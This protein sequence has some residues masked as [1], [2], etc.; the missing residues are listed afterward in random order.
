[1]ANILTTD[2]VAPRQRVAYWQEMVSRTFVQAHCDS[3]AGESFRGRISTAAFDQTEI[4]RIDAGPQRIQRRAVDIARACK[5]RFYL[6][7]HAAG[8]ARYREGHA[9]NVLGPGDMILLDNCEPYS[10]EY[11]EPVTSI[12]LH[13]PHEILRDR[14]RL[15]ERALGRRL[16][17][18]RG[19][20]RIAGEFLQSCIAQA[21]SLSPAQRAATAGVALDLFSSVLME[22]LGEHAGVGTHQAVLL[23]R[24]K[25][26]VNA[27]LGDPELNLGKLAAAMGVSMRHVSRLFQLDGTSFGRY[28]LQQRIEHCRRAL[29]NPALTAVRVSEIAAD[30]GF[31][32]F[33]HF[34]RVFRAALDRSPTEYRAEKTERK[35]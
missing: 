12:V 17:G 25:R 24:I 10:A 14:L 26:H 23:A 1:M 35:D 22:E 28:L 33:A 2:A 5:P 8:H 18:S 20:I 3:Q 13:V 16:S 34:S 15:P 7:Y 32:N 19:F 9:E 6:C 29:A 27:Q 30:N 11:Q 21:D 4:S 31:N